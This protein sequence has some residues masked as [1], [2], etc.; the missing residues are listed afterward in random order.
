MN[1]PAK[2]AHLPKSERQT[3]QDILLA[4]KPEIREMLNQGIGE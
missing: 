4:T 1:R 3:I 2:Y